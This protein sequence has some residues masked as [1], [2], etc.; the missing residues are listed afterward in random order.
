MDIAILSLAVS[1]GLARKLRVRAQPSEASN[2]S[3]QSLGYGG[4]LWRGG[5]FF[6]QKMGPRA[7]ELKKTIKKHPSGREGGETPKR[8]NAGFL[9]KDL[10]PYLSSFDLY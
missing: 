4:V 9:A 10:Y 7:R 3:F 2:A 6:W 8:A 1:L 5:S